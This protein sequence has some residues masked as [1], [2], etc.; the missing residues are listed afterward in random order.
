MACSYNG[1]AY[2][3]ENELSIATYLKMNEFKKKMLS[4]KGKHRIIYKV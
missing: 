3:S 1:T 2:H 4:E